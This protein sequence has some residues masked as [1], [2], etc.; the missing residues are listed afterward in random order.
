MELSKENNQSSGE[1][2]QPYAFFVYKVFSH[3]QSTFTHNQWMNLGQQSAGAKYLL[4][5]GCQSDARSREDLRGTV[6][7]KSGASF[8]SQEF[9]KT[10]YHA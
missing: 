6:V 4:C 10:I 9:S 1:E 5:V 3:L 8:L 2:Q 7:I